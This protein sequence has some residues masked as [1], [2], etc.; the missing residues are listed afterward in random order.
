MWHHYPPV[1]FEVEYR[2][3]SSTAE[4]LERRAV[5]V[6]SERFICDHR[7]GQYVASLLSVLR[8]I[9]ALHLDFISAVPEPWYVA[10]NAPAQLFS[11]LRHFKQLRS[12][13][14]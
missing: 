8:H 9:T 2:S 1:V 12:L 13:E 6:N 10:N 5:R 3:C 11:S 14:V 7:D 4:E